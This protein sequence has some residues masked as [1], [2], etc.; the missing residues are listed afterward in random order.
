MEVKNNLG[1]CIRTFGSEEQL[2]IGAV[3]VTVEDFFKNIIK[4][5]EGFIASKSKSI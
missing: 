5:N 4:K 1:I 3:R 2:W